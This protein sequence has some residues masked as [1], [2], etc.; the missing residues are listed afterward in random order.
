MGTVGNEEAD[1][2]A[3]EGCEK[4]QILSI[5]PPRCVLKQSIQRQFL[6]LWS[7]RWQN[8]GEAKHA[9]FFYKAFDITKTK[10]VIKLPRE[11]LGLFIRIITGH[12]SLH[13]H[14]GN[15]I[16]SIFH[17]C[18]FCLEKRES[19]VHFITDCPRLRSLRSD[20]FRDLPPSSEQ[21]WSVDKLLA[22]AR[23]PSILP[24]LRPD[25]IDD[26]IDEVSEDQFHQAQQSD[27][28]DPGYVYSENTIHSPRDVSE[29]SDQEYDDS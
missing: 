9:K 28:N 5:P 3:K 27:F 14:T 11:S 26:A 29:Y 8:N 21:G 24:L 16:E 1:R 22:F 7:T 12:N 18:R 17:K 15:F 10:F 2:L 13:A 6:A 23:S 25:L 20:F 4:D 19:F